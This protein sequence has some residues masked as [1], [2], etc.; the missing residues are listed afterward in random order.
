M[1]QKK[2]AKTIVFTIKMFIW[3]NQIIGNKIIANKDI[4]IP[5]DSRLSKISSSKKF[6]ENV[7][8]KINISSIMLDTLLYIS[9]WGGLENIKNKKL[10]E[11]VEKFKKVILSH[12]NV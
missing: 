6:W 9:L 4:F 8:K 5:I 12:I 11:K 2:D 1:K 7:L 3:W 10:K